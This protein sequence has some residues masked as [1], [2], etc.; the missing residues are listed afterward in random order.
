MLKILSR[1][2]IKHTLSQT[3]KKKKK[4]TTENEAAVE[5]PEGNS[6]FHI[7]IKERIN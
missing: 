3:F 2:T 4:K 6:T 5:T 7:P 1:I